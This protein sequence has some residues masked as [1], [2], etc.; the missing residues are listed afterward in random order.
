LLRA[1]GWEGQA[2]IFPAERFEAAQ[3]ACD[4]GGRQSGEGG[5]TMSKQGEQGGVHRELGDAEV[6]LGDGAYARYNGFEVWVWCERSHVGIC[7]VDHRDE[8]CLEWGAFVALLKF[9]KQIE[10]L[11]TWE[12]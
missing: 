7:N 8:V 4:S 1:T 11:K 5:G 3:V 10:W 2:G 9:A 6:Y 12:L